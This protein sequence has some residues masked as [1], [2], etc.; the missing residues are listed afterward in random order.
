VAIVDPSGDVL[1]FDTKPL[2]GR[3]LPYGESAAEVV[4]SVLRDLPGG[5]VEAGAQ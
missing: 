3:Y 1:W 5:K 4:E 2:Q